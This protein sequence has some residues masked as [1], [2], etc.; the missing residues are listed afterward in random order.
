MNERELLEGIICGKQR[1]F[2]LF[3][4]TYWEEFY[5]YV[6]RILHDQEESTDILQDTFA[7]IW[8]QRER[9]TDVQ[10]IKAYVYTIIHHKAVK[11]I[12]NNIKL[13][14]LKDEL[15]QYFPHHD[16][17]LAQE[18]NARELAVLIN[19]EIQNLPPRMREIFLLSRNEYLSYRQIAEQL[20]ISENTVKKQVS[21]SIKQLKQKIDAVY[22]TKSVSAVSI[23][24]ALTLM[25]AL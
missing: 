14:N 22:L 3:F 1:A 11:S 2:S 21:S 7:A 18:V 9:L 12:K 20:S 19:E 13:R 8:E 17:K 24:K 10:S 15:S 4:D 23:C 6:Y 25:D 5:A 16:D